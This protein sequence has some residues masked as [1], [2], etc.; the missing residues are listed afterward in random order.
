MSAVLV[1]QTFHLIVPVT[2]TVR[3][4]DDERV[5]ATKKSFNNEALAADPS[6][7]EGLAR[8]R[9]LLAKLLAHPE[10][11]RRQL[12]RHVAW[13]LD[14]IRGCEEILK[15]LSVA[16]ATDA[17]LVEAL[18]ESLPP[19]DVAFLRELCVDDCLYENTGFYQDAFA[20]E[21]GPVRLY[22]HADDL[23]TRRGH[24]ESRSEDGEDRS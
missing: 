23:A 3:E 13:A 5:E 7:E 2:V 11:L 16:E 9:H 8:D 12:L 18:A 24:D 1:Q 19:A 21:V 10:E 15:D 6:T 17:A 4:I 14:D 22:L 20:S